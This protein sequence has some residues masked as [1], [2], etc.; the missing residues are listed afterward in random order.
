MSDENI[1][2]VA[3]SPEES[4]QLAIVVMYGLCQSVRHGVVSPGYAVDKL[5]RPSLVK[6]LARCG[7]DPA[8]IDLV[9]HALEV[10]GVADLAPD[11]LG[12]LLEELEAGLLAALRRTRPQEGGASWLR[13]AK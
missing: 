12:P 7:A 4:V 6:A 10:D 3:T 13:S 5:F 11:R 9:E 2:F 8:L 1:G